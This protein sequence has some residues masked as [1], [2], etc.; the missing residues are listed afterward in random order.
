MNPTTYNKSASRQGSSVHGQVIA[1]VRGAACNDMD[2]N[3]Y[4]TC[5]KDTGVLTWKPR[6]F[7][8]VPYPNLR[9]GW[10]KRFAGKPAGLIDNQGY[11]SI[12][13]FMRHYGGHRII[14]EM[15]NGPIPKGMQIDHIDGN[16]R[17]N[18]ITNLR[19]AT[20]MQ[21]TQNRKVSKIS[22]SQLKGVYK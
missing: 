19:L 1:P 16:R 4:F 18:A 7:S 20:P 2:W 17:N 5:C 3:E 6:D 12:R 9:W 22:K 11:L 21:N 10:N 15:V 13:V 14:W 8:G